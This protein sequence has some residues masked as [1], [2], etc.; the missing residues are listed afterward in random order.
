MATDSSTKQTAAADIA[1]LLG[2]DTLHHQKMVMQTVDSS[3][4]P[5]KVSATA[6]VPVQETSATKT[7]LFRYLDTNGDGTGTVNATG[8]YSSGAEQ[9]YIAPGAGVIHKI[10]RL[11]VSV[12]D[13]T[14]MQAEEYGN[15][16]SALSNGIR[17]E[18]Q[19]DIGTTLNELDGGLN[20]TTNAE[21]GRLC[22]DVDVKTWGSG[23]ELLLVRWTF[24]RAGGPIVLD[25][26]NDDRLTVIVNDDLQG[27]LSHH[28]MVQGHIV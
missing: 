19:D 23:D 11:I 14:G 12:G 15:L 24:D 21:W 2:A 28:F 27:L 16:G 9:F 7:L 22:Y 5:S 25:G 20:V 18:V 3:G 8:D 4:E 6:P 17:I 10:H 13:G 26:D 1:T